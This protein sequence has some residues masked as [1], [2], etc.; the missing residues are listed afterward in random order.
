M[1][2]LLVVCMLLNDCKVVGYD[3]FCGMM[4]LI[5]VWVMYRDLKLWKEFEWFKLERF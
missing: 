2:L 3:M 1:L 4:L 5:N